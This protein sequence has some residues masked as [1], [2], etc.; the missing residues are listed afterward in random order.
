MEWFFPIAERHERDKVH[1]N[2]KKSTVGT[3]A[4]RTAKHGRR[5]RT[6][7]KIEAAP[8]AAAVVVRLYRCGVLLFC[9]TSVPKE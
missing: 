8:G 2:K 6:S 1:H 3:G 4:P 5:S 9:I 7:T